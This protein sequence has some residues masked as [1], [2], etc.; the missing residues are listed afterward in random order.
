MNDIHGMTLMTNRRNILLNGLRGGALLALG[1]IA[2][3]LGWHSLHGSCPRTNPCGGCPL[4]DGCALP[5]ALDAKQPAGPN[6]TIGATRTTRQ[7]HV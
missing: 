7:S 5:K 6:K 2:T 4:L 1:G 3:R